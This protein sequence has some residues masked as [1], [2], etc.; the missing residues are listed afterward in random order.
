MTRDLLERLAGLQS[1]LRRGHAVNVND[2]QTKEEAIAVGSAYFSTYHKALVKALGESELLLAHDKNWQDLI[3]LAHGNNARKSYLKIIRELQR[4][5]AELNV[6][7]LSRFSERPTRSDG[8]SDLTPAEQLII[9]TLESTVP[10]AGASYRQAI[11]DLRTERLSYR[12]TA[13][14]FRESLRETLDHLAPDNDV[15]AQPGFAL[16]QNQTTPTMKQ[17]AR[18]IL[19]VRGKNKSQRETAETSIELIDTLAAQITRAVY[20]QASLA[21]HVQSSRTE[22]WKVKRYIDTVFF[23][24][25]EISETALTRP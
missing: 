25:L 15:M 1:Q 20:N 19:K 16:E 9:R 3:R 12:G 10:C 22:V 5:L 14:E 2:R 23:D 6:A 4:E 21:T 17:K 13:S 24:L 7:S 11:L 18:Y 8:L